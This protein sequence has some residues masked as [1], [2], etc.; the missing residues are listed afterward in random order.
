[1]AKNP[2]LNP[3][4]W[5]KGGGFFT[6]GRYKI[7]D[8]RYVE[9][10]MKDKEQKSVGPASCA[11]HINATL[12]DENGKPIKRD[13]GDLIVMDRHIRVGDAT[14]WVP[15]DIDLNPTPGKAGPQFTLAPKAKKSILN[16]NSNIA[17]FTTYLENG[18][19]DVDRWEDQGA[20]GLNGCVV[21]FK[22]IPDERDLPER[23]EAPAMAGADSAKKDVKRRPRTLIVPDETLSYPEKNGRPIIIEGKAVEVPKRDVGAGTTAKSTKSDAASG[24]KT[25]GAARST[26]STQT[27]SG[28]SDGEADESDVV[29]AML[30]PLS[31]ILAEYASKGKTSL[32]K[33]LAIGKVQQLTKNQPDNIRSGISA[34]WKNEAMLGSLLESIGWKSTGSLLEKVAD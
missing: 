11:L 26:A 13:N 28:E 2:F 6:P 1:M 25:N 19:Y 14:D 4:N 15:A 29:A 3:A 8:A 22:E 9:Y 7:N 32:A 10:Q 12:V 24:G 31:E 33:P 21:S 5:Q 23:D 30:E 16:E 17:I 34:M 27:S 20:Y 18:G